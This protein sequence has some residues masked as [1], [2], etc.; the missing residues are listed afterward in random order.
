MSPNPHFPADMVT[1]TEESLN[2]KLHFLY[3]VINKK[4]ILKNLRKTLPL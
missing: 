3:S 4:L 2:G 1:F